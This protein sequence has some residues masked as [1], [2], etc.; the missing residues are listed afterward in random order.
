MQNEGK[1]KINPLVFCVFLEIS[2]WK[3][4]FC[5]SMKRE[6]GIMFVFRGF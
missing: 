3:R 1:C 2:P 4:I 5:S 6:C